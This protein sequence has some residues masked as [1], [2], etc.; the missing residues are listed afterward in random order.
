M[1]GA[2]AFVSA[3]GSIV[4]A[5][6][7]GKTETI[8]RAVKA[9]P[10]RQLVLTHTNAGVEALRRRMRRHGVAESSVVIDTVAGWCLKFV[11]AYPN[12]SGWAGQDSSEDRDWYDA[13]YPA[14]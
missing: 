5:A 2:E 4:A 12:S 6:G 7:C 8:A 14:M 3:S 11:T 1:L 10:G 13:L 9:S